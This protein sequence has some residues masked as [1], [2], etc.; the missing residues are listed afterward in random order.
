MQWP[1]SCAKWISTALAMRS[2]AGYT[3]SLKYKCIDYVD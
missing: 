2:L 3:I 1:V